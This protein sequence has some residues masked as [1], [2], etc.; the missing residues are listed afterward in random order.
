M[1]LI[2]TLTLAWLILCAALLSTGTQPLVIQQ[3]LYFA[4]VAI[5]VTLFL[6]ATAKKVQI[7]LP[8]LGV[9]A[10]AALSTPM[11][12]G[13]LIRAALLL[14]ALLAGQ[15]VNRHYLLFAAKYVGYGWFP[16]AI[17]FG[18]QM[19]NT[20]VLAMGIWALVFLNRERSAH[21]LLLACVAMVATQSEG[22]IIA[23]G[24]GLLVE[25]GNRKVM[26]ALVPVVLLT[27]WYKIGSTSVNSRL[28]MWQAAWAGFLDKPVFGNGLGTFTAVTDYGTFHVAHNIFADVAHNAGI[29]GLLALLAGVLWLWKN[30]DGIGNGYLA[31]FAVHSMVDAP[32]W[33]VPG[34][35]LMI[36]AGEVYGRAARNNY[37]HSDNDIGG[38]IGLDNGRH[39]PGP[40]VTGSPQVILDTRAADSVFGKR[41][42]AKLVS[43][44]FFTRLRRAFNL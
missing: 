13:P 18:N 22:G 11:N 44:R 10:V 30:K 33:G 16:L 29:F 23:L 32:Y 35:I 43:V 14:A 6:L 20:N 9:F 3:V 2:Y 8:A 27:T 12:S 28:A 36:L 17:I 21:W 37:Q 31:A 25:T 5:L 40:A 39:R 26:V 41:L 1:G 4:D 24:A 38:H 42:F 19:G 15:H 34:L 7:P